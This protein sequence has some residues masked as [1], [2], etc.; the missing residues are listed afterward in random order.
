MGVYTIGGIIRNTRIAMGMS[1]EQLAEGICM[2]NYLSRIECG[3]QVPQKK[4]FDK[5]MGRL[6]SHINRITTS[7]QVDEFELLEKE[8]EIARAIGD[9]NY[10]KAQ[11]LLWELEVELD[12]T[13][14]TNK[15][16][17]KFI[18]S[19]ID[20]RKKRI[21]I[22]EH[23]KILINSI[24][25]TILD[26]NE[27][28]KITRILS[29]TEIVVLINIYATYGQEGEYEK[30]IQLYEGLL[31]YYE[32]L[33]PRA[34]RVYYGLVL[35]HIGKWL[36][37]AGK[38]KEAIKFAKKGIEECKKTKRESM[39][40]TYFYTIA[41]NLKEL[42]KKDQKNKEKIKK[43]CKHYIIQAYGISLAYDYTLEQK[44]YLSKIK[45]WNSLLI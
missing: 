5:L 26:Y 31:N 29:R 15:Q 16:Y 22:Q 45:E 3:K 8:W 37:L 23:R 40:A 21:S 7:L 25:L 38:H 1:Q 6:E 44:F 33:Y 20:Y 43:A 36:G 27:M 28:W 10:Q 34:N 24:Q 2:P 14:P 32:E 41:W 9:F 11:E 35:E 39:L 30:A 13:Y 4:I 12:Q 19:S 17:M 42:I 18:Q